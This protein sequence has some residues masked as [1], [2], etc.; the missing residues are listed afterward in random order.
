[1]SGDGSDGRGLEAI[2]R[3][4][5]EPLMLGGVKWYAR[6]A[7]EKYYQ[8]PY[9]EVQVVRYVYQKAGGGQTFCALEQGAR[10]LLAQWEA[11]DTRTWERARD[12]ML[13]MLVMLE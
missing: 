11:T 1:M 5:G 3:P 9:G 8:M 12:Y 6:Q 2:R 7:K 10:K 4:D 13:D